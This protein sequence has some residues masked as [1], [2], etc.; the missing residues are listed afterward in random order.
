MNRTVLA[1]D[2]GST[3]VCAVIAEIGSDGEI[4]ITGAGVTKA[5]GLKRG[6]I[7]NI[8]LAAKSIK[9]A[10]E[11]ARRISGSTINSAIVSISGAYAKGI[12]SDGI[13]NIQS[14]E[15]TYSEIERVMQTALYNANIPHEFEV[16]HVLPYNFKIDD[17][18]SNIEDPLGMDASRLRAQVYIITTQKSFLNNLRKTVKTAGLEIENIVLSGYASLISTI[19]DDEKELGAVVIDMG[20]NS[21]NLA[22]HSGNSVRY[23]EFLGVGSHHVTTDLS[24]ALHT[25]IEEADKVKLRYGSLS[26]SGGGLIEVPTIGVE[27][28]KQEVS[29][30]VVRNVVYARVDET[31]KLL[32]HFLENSGL[33]KNIG[34]GVILTGGFSKMEGIRELAVAIFGSMPVRLARPKEL[35]GHFESLRGP[36]FAS[37]I[38]LVLYA[39]KPYT[40]YEID[41]N[42]HIRRN[43]I[44]P[45]EAKKSLSNLRESTVKQESL[46]K[47][48]LNSESSLDKS[49]VSKDGMVMLGAKKVKKAKDSN[50]PNVFNKIWNW[51]TQL[52]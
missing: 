45:S 26:E 40:L 35:N 42:K 4:S 37:A 33:I 27:S 24:M 2:I 31:L 39:A 32:A 17:Q 1:I 8:D 18:D 14:K 34:A 50:E 44:V 12:T 9:S 21:C 6:S 28:D 30:D 49:K 15:V 23:V 46:Q 48:D 5:Q 16:L 22:I 29:L 11:D 19:N 25:P 10:L 41:V 47:S 43:E 51:A 13:V 3:K 7:V 38:G 36:E 20:G 52:F